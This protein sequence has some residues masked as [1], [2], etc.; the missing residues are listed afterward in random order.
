MTKTKT[1]GEERV[2][3]HNK[4]MSNRYGRLKYLQNNS[5]KVNEKEEK[6]D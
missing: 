1:K 3:L 6:T 5:K 2:E 4:N